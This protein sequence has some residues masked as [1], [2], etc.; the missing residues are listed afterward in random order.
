MG[1]GRMILSLVGMSSMTGGGET[2]VTVHVTAPVNP[3]SASNFCTGR[4]DTAAGGGG[5]WSWTDVV[6]SST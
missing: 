3:T 1:T 6:W 4:F 2:G 5:G